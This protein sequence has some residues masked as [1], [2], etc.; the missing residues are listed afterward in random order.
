MRDTMSPAM[1]LRVSISCLGLVA[2]PACNDP[3][4]GD[5]LPPGAFTTGLDGDPDVGEDTSGSGGETND[6]TTTSA[7]TGSGDG[8]AVLSYAGDIQPIWDANGCLDPSCHD[9][10]APAGSLDLQ[11]E[12]AYDRLCTRN[13]ST[14]TSINLVDCDGHDPNE[15][16]LYRKVTGD[17]DLPGA[18]S[19]MPVGGMLTSE[20]MA[21]IGAWISGGALP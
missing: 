14:I 13:S 10:D 16:W 21:T 2:L 18:G 7:D 6:G 19:L 1:Y 8:P 15:S 12:G 11:S 4:T 3:G 17:I 5:D 9:S 20:E